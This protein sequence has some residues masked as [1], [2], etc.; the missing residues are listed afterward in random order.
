MYAT[1]MLN[2]CTLQ[3]G[4]NDLTIGFS[5]SRKGHDTLNTQFVT[6]GASVLQLLYHII[7]RFERTSVLLIHEFLLRS[8]RFKTKTYDLG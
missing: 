1:T 5:I 6:I 7:V 2:L 3:A 8:S 4:Q